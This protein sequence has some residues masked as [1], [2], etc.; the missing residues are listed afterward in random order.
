[1]S[2]EIAN[3]KQEGIEILTLTG[4]LTFGQGDLDI[5]AE[6]DRLIAAGKTRVLLNLSHLARLD[7]VG[8]GTL[9]FAHEALRRSGGNL[10][11]FNMHPSHIEFL[12]EAELQ[13]MLEIFQTEQDAI[14]SFFPD[15]ESKR[16]DI[17]AF[18][19]SR[20]PSNPSAS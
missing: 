1:M 6:L 16:Y 8:L 3:R 2:L 18:V 10:A 9:L 12:V 20:K 5:R 14:N 11:I 17:L 13:T 7:R 19:E 4:Q 15:R